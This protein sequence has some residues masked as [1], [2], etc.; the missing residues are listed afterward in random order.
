MNEEKGRPE[1]Q[2]HRDCSDVHNLRRRNHRICRDCYQKDCVEKPNTRHVLWQRA[3]RGPKRMEMDASRSRDGEPGVETNG[4]S[5]RRHEQ[6]R[7]LASW[8]V[9]V[10]APS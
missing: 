7:I 9:S 2:R 3:E 8:S 1:H 10:S 6:D 4:P 5:R